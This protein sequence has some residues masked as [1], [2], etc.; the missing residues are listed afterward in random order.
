MD[1]EK[2][3]KKETGLDA[4]VDNDLQPKIPLGYYVEWLEQKLTIPVV[5]VTSCDCNKPRYLDK[6]DLLRCIECD[7]VSVIV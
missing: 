6:E 1:L 7:K 4:Y 2:E 5:G 3:F